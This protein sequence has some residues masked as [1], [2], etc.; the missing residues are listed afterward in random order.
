[1]EARQNPLGAYVRLDRVRREHRAKIAAE[2]ADIETV[3]SGVEDLMSDETSYDGWLP[4]CDQW[5]G[6][7]AP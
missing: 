2:I 5:R 6:G 1:L 4:Q 7:D 3:L